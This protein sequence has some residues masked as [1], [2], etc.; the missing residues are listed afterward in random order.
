MSDRRSRGRASWPPSGPRLRWESYAAALENAQTRQVDRPE[1]WSARSLIPD[2]EDEPRTFERP[3][4]IVMQD[5]VR[6]NLGLRDARAT[7]APAPASDPA[8]VLAAATTADGAPQGVVSVA[9]APESLKGA[10][11][12]VHQLVGDEASTNPALCG[13]FLGILGSTSVRKS[14]LCGTFISRVNRRR[15]ALREGTTPSR[16]G[17]NGPKIEKKPPTSS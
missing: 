5:F 4:T 13:D 9:W 2:P 15:R 16:I 7:E 8:S 14:I 17:P 6:E 12:V 1:E 10:T 11:Q 3:N